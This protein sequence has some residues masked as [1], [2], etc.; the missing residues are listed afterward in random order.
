MKTHYWPYNT[1]Y[2]IHCYI[3]NRWIDHSHAMIASK[4]HIKRGQWC[5]VDY[6]FLPCLFDTLVNFVE[7]ECAWEATW[8]NDK[9]NVPFWQNIKLLRLGGW[10]SREAGIDNLR[11]AMALINDENNNY[12]PSDKGYGQPTQQ[13]IAA[14]EILDLYLWWTDVYPLRPDAHIASGF[15]AYC[16]EKRKLGGNLLDFNH[17]NESEE[18]KKRG[19]K[20][21]KLSRKLE[22][23]YE[24]EDTDHLIRLIKIRHSLWT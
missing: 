6:R 22:E 18:L 3:R 4:D 16:E 1:L 2:N 17:L 10:R 5:D 24:K 7:Q 9:Y 11:W 19:K 21:F 20:A 13:A 14:K 8:N 12:Q 15:S 23:Q